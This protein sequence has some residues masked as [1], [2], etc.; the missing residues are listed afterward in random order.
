MS[1]YRLPT[2]TIEGHQIG[3]LVIGTNW[4]L[5]YSHISAAKSRWI[6]RYHD[7]GTIAEV[8]EVCSAGGMN[9]FVA[10]VSE[11][12]TEAVR[13]HEER[14]GRA[15]IQVLTPGGKTTEELMEGIDQAAE[16]G[17]QFCLPHTSWV[18]ARI[19]TARQEIEDW[20]RVAEHIRERGMIPGLSTHRPEAIVVGDAAGYDIATYIQPLNSIGF[21]CAVETDWMA[22]VINRTE[23]PVICIKPLAA[24]RVN[25]PTGLSFA[26][27]NIKPID[28]VCIGLLSP[29]EAEEDLEIV[30][31]IFEHQRAQVEL[32][33]SR[34]KAALTGE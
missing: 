12:M 10:P 23:K 21:L 7:A 22:G 30:R 28:M 3:R 8:L 9:A 15:L 24:G 16:L 1:D 11:L 32:Q 26:F 14:T 20:P 2:T 5:G 4:F 33:Y 29:E 17:A 31:Q 18:D 6:K 19:S 27:G 34:S 25:P 13:L